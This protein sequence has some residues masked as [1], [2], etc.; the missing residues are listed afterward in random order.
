MGICAFVPR[1]R[2]AIGAVKGLQIRP[3]NKKIQSRNQGQA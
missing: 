2:I 1:R 3:D